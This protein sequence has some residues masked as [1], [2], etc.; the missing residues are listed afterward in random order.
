M[1]FPG[2][3]ATWVRVIP[4]Y[5]IINVLDG[6]INYGATWADSWQSLAYAAVWLVVLFGAGVF[7]LKRK[8]ES[9]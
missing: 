9:L 7:A 4:T 6:A 1:L 3:A 2:T 5:P 8:V